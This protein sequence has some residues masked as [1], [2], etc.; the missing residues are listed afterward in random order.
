MLSQLRYVSLQLE[1]QKIERSVTQRY[2]ATV[3]VFYMCVC[4]CVGVLMGY[5]ARVL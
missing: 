1:Q 4:V 5:H 3:Y 2:L